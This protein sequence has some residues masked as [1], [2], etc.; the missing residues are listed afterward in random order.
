MELSPVLLTACALLLSV[1]IGVPQ[2]SLPYRT[3]YSP[4]E[5][6]WHYDTAALEEERDTVPLWLYIQM[7]AARPG[8][9]DQWYPIEEGAIPLEEGWHYAAAPGRDK[10]CLGEDRISYGCPTMVGHTPVLV[11]LSAVQ[12]LT[13]AQ[14]AENW[15]KIQ[16]QL[17]KQVMQQ[18]Q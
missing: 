1:Q 2:Q 12:P 16:P 3:V 10:V 15:E 18:N 7:P 14:L 5:S 17:E 8:E 9:M 6:K 4:V 13:P 11:V